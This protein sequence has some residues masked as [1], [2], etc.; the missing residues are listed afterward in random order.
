[1][2]DGLTPAAS[3]ELLW[4]YGLIDIPEQLA[5]TAAALGHHPLALMV[6]ARS[7]CTGA[8]ALNALEKSPKELPP[9]QRALASLQGLRPHAMEALTLLALRGGTLQ[10]VDLKALAEY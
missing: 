3:A 2:L 10:P 5:R 7:F 9:L 4:S 8:A 6:A 1:E